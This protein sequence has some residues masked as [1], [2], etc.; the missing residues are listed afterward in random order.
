MAHPCI[1]IDWTLKEV[2]EELLA[3]KSANRVPV[4]MIDDGGS[5]HFYYNI[6]TNPTLMNIEKVIN[7]IGDNIKLKDAVRWYELNIAECVEKINAK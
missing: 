6:R 4:F 2:K 7:K 1:T 5:G 3:A